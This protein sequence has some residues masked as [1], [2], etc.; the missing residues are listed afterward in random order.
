MALNHGIRVQ[1]SGGGPIVINSTSSGNKNMNENTFELLGIDDIK[2]NIKNYNTGHFA[3]YL[4]VYLKDMLMPSTVID[5]KT[6]KI[7]AVHD[8]PINELLLANAHTNKDLFQF[9]IGNIKKAH[10]V[11][12]NSNINDYNHGRYVLSFD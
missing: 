8:S 12:K 10:D 3:G 9:L 5:R 1:L 6:K 2:N 7:I 11:I 4:M